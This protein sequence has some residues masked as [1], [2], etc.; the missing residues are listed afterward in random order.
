MFSFQ[1]LESKLSC[2][3]L[4]KREKLVRGKLEDLRAEK[5]TRLMKLKMFL[6][7]EQLLC[8]CL[9]LSPSCN[10]HDRVPS[11]V[12]LRD[13]ADHLDSLRTKKV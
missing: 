6:D 5:D 9:G 12:E 7:E 13:L 3:A 1:D 4:Y 2:I 11:L 8:N 10:L